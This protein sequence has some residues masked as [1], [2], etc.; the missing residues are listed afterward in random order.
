MHRDAAESKA[1]LIIKKGKNMIKIYVCG[2][3]VSGEYSPI[4]SDSINYLEAFFSFS[5]DWYGLEK[6]AQF[7]QNG[8]TYNVLLEKNKCLLPSE[9][10]EG[11]MDISVFGQQP[12]GARR[13]TTLPFS[14]VMKK[15]AFVFDGDTPIPPAPDLYS[16]L[17]GRVNDAVS[18]IP[19]RLSEFENDTGFVTEKDV[20]K[21]TSDLINDAGFITEQDIPEVEVPTKVSELTNDAGYIAPTLSNQLSLSGATVDISGGSVTIGQATYGFSVSG[22]RIQNIGAPEMN[23]DAATKG[24][25]DNAVQ[26]VKVPAKLSELTNDANFVAAKDIT[27]I[28]SFGDYDN[29]YVGMAGAYQDVSNWYEGMIVKIKNSSMPL[30]YVAKG[31]SENNI[32]ATEEECIA[33]LEESG[34]VKGNEIVFRK[35]SEILGGDMG[36]ISSALDSIIS[37]QNSMIGGESA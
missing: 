32:P 31:A 5:P 30:L 35:Y 36:D 16:Q 14:M 15:S 11:F 9:L 29:F 20:P 18:G 4:A 25:V 12:D 24:Y 22:N 13:I 26:N 6:T 7:T 2:Q 34:S 23:T 21:N 17:I 1:E 3:S 37:M 8:K 19:S 33:I 27:A 28:F 10:A